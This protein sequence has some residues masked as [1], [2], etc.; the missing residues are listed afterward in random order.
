M[1]HKTSTEKH[2]ENTACSK[3]RS[4]WLCYA[5]ATYT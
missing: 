1:S 3:A 4:P 2:S 5:W